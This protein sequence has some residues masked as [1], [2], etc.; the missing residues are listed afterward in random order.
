MA[1]GHCAEQR[2]EL[3]RH[4]RLTAGPLQASPA[5]VS[6]GVN[7]TP[8][9]QLVR[10]RLPGVNSTRVL[11]ASPLC[12]LTGDLLPEESGPTEASA[13]GTA[14]ASGGFAVLPFE[15]KRSLRGF[16]EFQDPLWFLTAFPRGPP[17]LVPTDAAGLAHGAPGPGIVP[18]PLGPATARLLL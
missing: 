8:R 14:W 9:L 16:G 11:C 2:Q 15:T 18:S 13:L 3:G 7:R 10:L 5:C 6:V 17:W 12:T 4:R 1:K